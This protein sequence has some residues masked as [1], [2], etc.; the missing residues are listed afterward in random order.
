MANT[1][2]YKVNKLT[3]SASSSSTRATCLAY[4]A[5]CT[6]RLS[7]SSNASCSCWWIAW[8][9]KKLLARENSRHFA[10]PPLVSPRNDVWGTSAEIPYWWR[11]TTQIWVVLRI[12]GGN[13]LTNHST[14]QIWTVTRHQYGMS[15]LVPQTSFGGETS[16]GV[17]KSRLFTQA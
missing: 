3:F 7:C 11:V 17:A 6:L 14:N 15:A 1:R 9:K 12:G 13:F 4:S 16:S 10:P 5:I 8:N 2:A